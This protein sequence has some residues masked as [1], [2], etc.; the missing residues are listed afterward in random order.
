MRAE[1][2]ALLARAN[3][4]DTDGDGVSDGVELKGSLN[5]FLTDP[6]N[7]DTDGDGTPDGQDGAP[8]DHLS[9]APAPAEFRTRMVLA[10]AAVSLTRTAKSKE[11]AISN[12]GSGELEWVAVAADPGLITVTPETGAGGRQLTVAAPTT[13]G[14]DFYGSVRTAVYV[15][16]VTGPRKPPQAVQ[17]LV[18]GDQGHEHG[19]INGNGLRIW[20]M[21]CWACRSPQG[22]HRRCPATPIP[23]ARMRTGTRGWD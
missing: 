16:D 13:L 21:R 12:E 4:A 15:F 22:S 14:F 18:K 17:V 6:L 10:P 9:V 8:L 5:G 23:Q 19:D 11:V 3:L 20:P 1:E 7:P 2:E